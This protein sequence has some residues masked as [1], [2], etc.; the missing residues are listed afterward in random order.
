MFLKLIKRHLGEQSDSPKSGAISI[1]RSTGSSFRAERKSQL[2]T[3]S[4]SFTLWTFRKKA[5]LCSR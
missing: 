4:Q 3:S 2:R 5:H 1:W